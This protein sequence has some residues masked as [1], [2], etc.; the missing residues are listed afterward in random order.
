M[1]EEVVNGRVEKKIDHIIDQISDLRV[2]VT[3]IRERTDAHIVWRE[4][5]ERT[6][7][8]T[9]PLRDELAACIQQTK[10]AVEQVATLTTSVVA[11]EEC[12]EA[13]QNKLIRF[14]KW[15]A[16]GVIGGITLL[17]GV[18]GLLAALHV[19]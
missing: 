17:G 2:Q 7:P 9:C 19:F 3:E 1:A 6:R 12:V 4:S 14:P 15:L 11:L 10:I 13:H 16:A 8:L 18:I 5:W